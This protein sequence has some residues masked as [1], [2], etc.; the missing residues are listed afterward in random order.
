MTSCGGS[1]LGLVG[2]NNVQNNFQSNVPSRTYRKDDTLSDF[3][4]GSQSGG[5]RVTLTL[6]NDGAAVRD[7]HAYDRNRVSH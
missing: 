4:Q 3:F 1:F 2:C 6:H 5:F 7:L